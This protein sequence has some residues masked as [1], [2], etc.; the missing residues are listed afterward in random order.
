M[1]YGARAWEFTHARV[2]VYGRSV[3]RSGYINITR[4]QEN[5]Q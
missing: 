3:A 1:V 4:W 5:R 2:C